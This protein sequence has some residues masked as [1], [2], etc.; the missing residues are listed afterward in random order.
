MNR[1]TLALV[2]GFAIAYATGCGSSEEAAEACTVYGLSG[3]P[4]MNYQA[5]GCPGG[6]SY[7]VVC[8]E[9][10][11]STECQCTKDGVVGSTFT[12]ADGRIPGDYADATRTV[13]Q[14]CGWQIPQRNW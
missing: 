8:T 9:S 4:G 13:N 7:E 5:D 11:G 14:G 6:A 12:P 1:L 10:E 2:A 3:T